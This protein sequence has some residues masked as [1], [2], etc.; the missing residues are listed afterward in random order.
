MTIGWKVVTLMLTLMFVKRSPSWLLREQVQF[1]I[2]PLVHQCWESTEQI[3]LFH[4]IFMQFQGGNTN[5]A[6]HAYPHRATNIVVTNRNTPTGM[7]WDG[8]NLVKMHL[9]LQ[10][11]W[12]TMSTWT[13]L[14]NCWKFQTRSRN[15]F[16][17]LCRLFWTI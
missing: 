5:F 8:Q 9:W 1:P 7:A 6:L 4:T 14:T 10:G 12:C 17:V 3:K 2:L 13:M 15:K 11:L 16:Y